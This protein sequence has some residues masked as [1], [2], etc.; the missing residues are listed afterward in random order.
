MAEWIFNEWER[1]SYLTVDT[2]EIITTLEKK[3]R[4]VR[5]KDCDS[6]R[7]YTWFDQWLKKEYLLREC[8]WFDCKVEP[9]G[10]CAWGEEREE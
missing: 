10:F 8:L 2:N 9:D 1:S 7:E 4:I 3:E 5:C 6:Y